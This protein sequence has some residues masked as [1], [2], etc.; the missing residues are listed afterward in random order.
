[1]DFT[2]DGKQVGMPDWTLANF[3]GFDGSGNGYQLDADNKVGLL[4]NNGASAIVDYKP[5]S[6]NEY[7][8]SFKFRTQNS[9][10]EEKL[11]ECVSGN[12][13]FELYPEKVVMMH[14]GVTIQREFDSQSIHE[15]TL[16][17]YGATYQ[18]LMIIY[19][20]GSMQ[21]VIQ[22]GNTQSTHQQNI[23][24][25]ST[26]SQFYLYSFK[27]YSR[28]LSYTEVQ[29][30]YGLNLGS[31]EEITNY[32]NANNVFNTDTTSIKNGGYG[33]N[34]K[35]STL[36]VGARYLVLESY[37]G[38]EVASQDPTP[39]KTINGYLSNPESQKGI[40]HYLNSVKLIEKTV[41]GSA[42]S[43]NFYADKAALAAQGTSSMAY[44]AKNFRIAFKKKVSDGQPYA[45]EANEVGYTQHFYTGIDA[46]FDISTTQLTSKSAKYAIE[47]GMAAKIF[48]L[49]ADF[50]ESSGSHNTGFARMVDYVMRNSA[51]ISDSTDSNFSDNPNN[52]ANVNAHWLP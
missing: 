31:A 39:W 20:D 41:D 22:K 13:G 29:S 14:S 50:A 40:Y 30:L 7:T 6:T 45:N 1:M 34:V 35:I 28:A 44:P 5:C 9:I 26:K 42:S 16:V 3:F 49:K 36:P 12:T 52:V 15:V 37:K 23:T 33:D 32:V 18:N 51:D 38:D 43:I 27:A 19:I 8:V 2:T 24:I 21:A 25:Q 10:D 46:D 11:I 4:F 48:C 47:G 17:S